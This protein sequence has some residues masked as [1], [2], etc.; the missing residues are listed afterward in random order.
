VET[1]TIAAGLPVRSARLRPGRLAKLL[2]GW[3]DRSFEPHRASELAASNVARDG[4]NAA[5]PAH[6]RPRD[7]ARPGLLQVE[8]QSGESA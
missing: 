4:F 2:A 5:Q 3:I 1:L 8:K 7:L 6:V